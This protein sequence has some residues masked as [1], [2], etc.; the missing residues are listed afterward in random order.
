MNKN[1]FIKSLAM[2]LTISLVVPSV[3][4]IAPPKAQAQ[5]AEAMD[6]FSGLGGEAGGEAAAAVL[7]VPT[8]ETNPILVGATVKTTV[9]STV[10]A[11]HSVLSWALDV[12][13]TAA[14]VAQ[15]ANLYLGAIAFVLSGNMMKMLTS[16]VI[17]FVIGK[18]NGTGVPQFVVDVRRSMQTVSDGQALA[19]LRQINQ[20]NS[21]FAGSIA[22]ALSSSYFK[23]SSLKGFWDANLCTLDRMSP[24]VN[25]PAYLAGNWSR[26][27][28]TAW[29]ALTTQVQNNPYTLYSTLEAQMQS[30]I[31]PGVSGATGARSQ[32]LAWGN[33]FMSWCGTSATATQASNFAANAAQ[34]TATAAPGSVECTS[35]NSAFVD[36]FGSCYNSAAD[37]AAADQI[38]SAAST[39]AN[40]GA[41]MTAAGGTGINPGDSCTN[42]D[43]TPGTIQTPGSTIKATLDKV[44][45]GQQDQINRM[46]NVGPQINS[47]LKD[48]A[49]IIDTVNFASSL[50]GGG[51][52]GGLVGVDNTSASNPSSR[53][54]EFA[55]TKDS[56]GNFT[57]GYAGVTQSGIFQTAAGD[58]SSGTDKNDLI[59]RY[60]KAWFT[61]NTAATAAQTSVTSLA[62]F[63][64]AAATAA[65][66]Q[67]QSQPESNLQPFID[68][69][70]QQAATAQSVLTDVITPVLARDVA[71]AEVIR[72]ARQM[73]AKVQ[74]E[75][76]A[77]TAATGGEYVADFERLQTMPP[78]LTDVGEALKQAQ[79]LGGATATASP[80]GSLNVSARSLVD[81][82]NLISTNAE[83][84]KISVCTPGG[85]VI[86]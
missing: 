85:K 66:V 54:K 64:T 69:S 2:L 42:P 61:I 8:V 31:G 65:E 71:A 51:N 75:L 19:Y 81:Q 52:S 84:L 18:A 24:N 56:S 9:E 14:Q 49:S 76:N 12:T 39:L 48:V 43:G 57:S 15:I 83:A 74:I 1:P 58:G 20:T 21:P 46:G 10:S 13:S 32:E 37:A 17:N 38:N 25:V 63:C 22:L 62:S 33:G 11:I 72:L 4:L 40:T 70:T 50:L 35:S 79:A 59:G 6:L 86:N 82:M 28:V 73:V 7:G 78:S 67:M 23:R 5:T 34:T 30:Q 55:P 77:P 26:G 80:E 3:F 16:S 36:S 60:E 41:G 29:F 44:L 68:A 27:G 45:G 47:I 53:L